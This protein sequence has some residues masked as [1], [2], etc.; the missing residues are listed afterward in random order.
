MELI[1]KNRTGFTKSRMKRKSN[2]KVTALTMKDMRSVKVTGIITPIQ[3]MISRDVDGVEEK[4][5]ARGNYKKRH[6][7][8]NVEEGEGLRKHRARNEKPWGRSQW[9]TTLV[10]NTD[11]LNKCYNSLD[12]REELEDG[13]EYLAI[14]R[15]QHG[16][17]R[18]QRDEE[19]AFVEPY[20]FEER[21]GAVPLWGDYSIRDDE[22]IFKLKHIGWNRPG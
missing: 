15:A 10:H 16:F 11:I 9:N 2:P 21:Y 8:E 17:S 7:V 1:D 19:G 6:T 18:C 12:N 22:R 14:V 13:N 5:T 4:L 20:V 3:R